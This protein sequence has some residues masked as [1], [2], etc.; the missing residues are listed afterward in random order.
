MGIELTGQVPYKTVYLHGL[1]RDSTGKKISKSMEDVDKY[2]PLLIIDKLGADSL[3]YVLIS[4]SVPGLD[5]NLD[6]RNLEAAHRFCNK[7]WQ[8][9]RY[10][11]SNITEE[12]LLKP[13]AE[14]DPALFQF[15]DRWILSRLNHVIRDVTDYMEA[16]D[17]L[18]A[19]RELKNFFWSEFCDWYI[20]MSKVHLYNEAHTEKFVQ[21]SV[22]LHVL[23]SF[24]R[25]I[26]P[27]MPFITE[28]L[29]QTLPEY[30]KEGPSI[31]VAS[32]PRVTAAFLDTDV[33]HSFHVIS[34]FIREIRRV[35]HDFGIPLKSLVPI[36]I[37]LGSSPNVFEIGQI[38]F[39]TM[40]NIDPTQ[41]VIA[42]SITPP[43]QAAHIALHGITGYIPLQGIID[44]D[45]EYVRQR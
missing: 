19:A 17:Y 35:K 18:K 44:L 43:D 45:A 25:L 29:W 16:Y 27:I 31:M 23:D 40:A 42:K 34:E 15:S 36:Q 5:T 21:Q 30:L 13:I 11:F 4:N 33:E 39:L 37:A 3:R 7:I 28:K 26:H 14:L 10:V 32:W 8:A 2:D 6:P 1:I 12:T 20:E 9:S 38:E 41:F 24:Y 22:L